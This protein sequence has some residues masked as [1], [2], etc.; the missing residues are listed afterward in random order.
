MVPCIYSCVD[1]DVDPPAA[2]VVKE[3]TTLHTTGGYDKPEL[4]RGGSLDETVTYLGSS[5]G[6]VSFDYLDSPLR[7][8]VNSPVG[9]PIHGNCNKYCNSQLT[10]INAQL[11]DFTGF[12]SLVSFGSP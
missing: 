9:M 11:T 4:A 2:G 10:W 6:S 8:R 1:D 7:S 3:E 5:V 12:T